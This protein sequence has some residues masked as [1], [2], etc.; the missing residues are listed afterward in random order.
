MTSQ[1]KLLALSEPTGHDSLLL[2]DRAQEGGTQLGDLG[3]VGVATPSR[4]LVAGAKPA[5]LVPSVAAVR[6]PLGHM[7]SQEGGVF[8]QTSLHW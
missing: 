6:H 5:P 1:A 2:G 3:R 8:Q 7:M 4:C